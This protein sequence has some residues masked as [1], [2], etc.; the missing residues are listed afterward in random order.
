M[1]DQ[2]YRHNKR[3]QDM[4]RDLFFAFQKDP[5]LLPKSHRLRI[6]DSSVERVICDYVAGMTDVYAQK[7]HGFLGL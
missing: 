5:K 4:I 7:E 3:G 2:V 6:K 1:D